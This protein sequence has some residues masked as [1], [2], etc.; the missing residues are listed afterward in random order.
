MVLAI[1]GSFFCHNNADVNFF[2]VVLLFG[3][4]TVHVITAI[5]RYGLEAVIFESRADISYYIFCIPYLL[6]ILTDKS[7][8]VKK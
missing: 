3:I 4:V 6:L 8:A 5:Y 2:S 1:I 7:V